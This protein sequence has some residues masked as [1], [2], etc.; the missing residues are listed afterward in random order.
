MLF[1][2]K[3]KLNGAQKTVSEVTDWAEKNGIRKA[4]EI[5]NFLEISIIGLKIKQE[6]TIGS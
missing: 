6:C 5:R 1:F 2:W 4:F 3:L